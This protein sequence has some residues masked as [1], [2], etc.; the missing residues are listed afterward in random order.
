[1]SQVTAKDF[2]SAKRRLVAAFKKGDNL[3]LHEG[4]KCLLEKVVNY[5][6][7]HRGK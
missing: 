1:M 6:K 4:S 5:L 2:D 3:V 7:I